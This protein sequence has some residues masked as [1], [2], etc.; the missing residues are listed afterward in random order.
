MRGV[1]SRDAAIGRMKGWGGE[2]PVFIRH[3][4][5]LQQA[6]VQNVKGSQYFL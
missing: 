3:A 5:S 2:R 1:S 4:G 6:R